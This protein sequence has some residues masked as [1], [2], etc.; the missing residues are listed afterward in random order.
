MLYSLQSLKELWQKTYRGQDIEYIE[1]RTDSVDSG[2]SSYSYRVL[3]HC[4][5][6]ELDMRGRCSAG[7][8]VPHLFPLCSCLC[9]VVAEKL[10]IH[11]ILCVYVLI[12]MPL[13]FRITFSG[14]YL[15][16]S[17]QVDR[18]RVPHSRCCTHAV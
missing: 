2:R 13:A 12:D 6:A 14:W 4:G 10:S 1:I 3:M 11:C 17:M 9:G 7:Q 15:L 18:Y 5:D 8:K 16:A